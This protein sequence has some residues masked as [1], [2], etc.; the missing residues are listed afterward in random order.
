MC[1]FHA[2]TMAR[3]LVTL[4][5]VAKEVEQLRELVQGLNP[6]PE[7]IKKCEAVLRGR[8]L[9]A[10]AYLK[11]VRRQLAVITRNRAKRAQLLSRNGEFSLMETQQNF[12]PAKN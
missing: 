8:V 5:S 1:S 12:F 4:H 11:E 10:I 7:E 3:L 2:G 6:S 9:R